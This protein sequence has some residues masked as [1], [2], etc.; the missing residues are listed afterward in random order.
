MRI[1]ATGTELFECRT[2]AGKGAH[3]AQVAI[4]SSSTRSLFLALLLRVSYSV[5]TFVACDK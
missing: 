1:M 5:T 2:G 3:K 4:G